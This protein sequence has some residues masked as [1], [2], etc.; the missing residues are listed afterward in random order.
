MQHAPI[1]VM[2]FNRPEYLRRVLVSLKEQ[3]GINL[4]DHTITL[5]QDGAVNLQSGKRYADDEVIDGNC[6]IFG[7]IFP[8]GR[9]K[10]AEH[11]LGVALNFERAEAYAFEELESPYAIFLEDDL[12]LGP[13]YLRTIFKLGALALNR[14]DVGY[15]AAYGN[16][17]ASIDHQK[18]NA[19]IIRAL[20]HNW[21]FG[22]TRA[23]WQR[24][25][26]YIEQYLALVRNVDYRDRP[27][28]KIFELMKSWGVG[29][30][31]SSQ[32]VAKSIAC[33]LTG[34]CKI[35]TTPAFGRYIGEIGL[36]STRKFFADNRFEQT[37]VMEQDV[38]EKTSFTEKEIQDAKIILRSYTLEICQEARDTVFNN[39]PSKLFQ[40]IF[41]CNPYDGFTPTIAEP[42]L[43][44]WNGLHPALVRFVEQDKPEVIIDLGVWKGQ[45][46]ITLAKA[47]QR[48]KENGIVIAVDSFLGSPEHWSIKRQDIHG[49][50]LFRNGRPN[51]YETFLSNVV[52]SGLSSRIIP[53]A[54]TS[55]NAA[56]ILKR[57]GVRPNF[58][59]I[60]AAH[61]Y[62]PCL[63]DMELFW[64]ILT[65]G[66]LLM[67]DD[68][69]WPGVATAVVHFS[70]KHKV[71]FSVEHPKWWIRKPN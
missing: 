59:H 65:P 38:F 58:V 18:Q 47:Q 7:E 64:D 67:G 63:R 43:Q 19:N 15:F 31:T 57:N 17:L 35:N 23:Q 40:E 70:G 30:P 27:H 61:E 37:Q 20:G 14:D 71:P 6:Q 2:A 3:K 69:P 52:L 36:H 28:R 12:E 48:V 21:A 50:L 68:F 49:S 46:T 11:N 55:E 5:F 66:G 9:I 62:E 45:S 22:L 56:L 25:K 33:H 34:G 13:Y 4:E 29:A 10:R 24:S 51:F 41:G 53:I 44:G 8:N 26:P 1:I 60:D 42:D 32:D 16:H 54:Q 39:L